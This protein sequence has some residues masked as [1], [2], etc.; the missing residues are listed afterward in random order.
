MSPSAGSFIY[1]YMYIRV[2]LLRCI[3]VTA[4]AAAREQV[5]VN[6]YVKHLSNIRGE[7]KTLKFVVVYFVF[8]LDTTVIII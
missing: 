1:I 2:T 5:H 8:T 3:L 6:T 7:K 4:A